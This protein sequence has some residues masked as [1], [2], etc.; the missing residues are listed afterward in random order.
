MSANIDLVLDSGGT[1]ILSGTIPT[2]TKNDTYTFRLRMQDLSAG[3]TPQDVD[4]S[5]STIKLAIG[6]INE[7]PTDGQF[8]LTLAGPVTSTAISFNATTTQFFN[9]IS[10]IAGNATVTTYGISSG[11]WL[12]TAATANT[13]L[14][15]GADSYTLFPSSSV[16]V[17]TRRNPATAVNAQQVVQLRRNPAVYANNFSP[18]STASAIVLTKVQDGGSGKNEVYQLSIQADA[19]G[20]SFYF[21]FG[22]NTTTGV[23]IGASA[24]CISEALQSLPNIGINNISTQTLPN[25]QGYSISFIGSLGSQNITTPLSIDAAGVYFAKWMSS[26]ITM[27]T[28]ELD[29]LFSET[30][31]LVITPTLEIELVDVGNPKTLYQGTVAVRSDL[32]TSGSVVP[33]PK[34]SYYTKAEA[35]NLFVED[36][37]T[38]V[39]A[40]NRKLRASNG[41]ERLRWDNGLGFFGATAVS[42][43]ANVN[44]ASGLVNLGLFASSSTYGVLPLSVKTLTVTTAIDFGTINSNDI[45]Y[46]N[47]TVTGANINDIV[48]VGLPNAVSDGLVIQGLVVTANTVCLSAINGLNASKHLGS[49]TFRIVVVG[50]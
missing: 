22:G 17:S 30:S 47:V 29:E 9:A 35:D 24:V 38:N 39:D 36:S 13:A 42:Q 4:I 31:S 25:G 14:S 26:S 7:L 10:A 45:H 50:Y 21:D 12:I 8:K 20:G 40:S 33:A 15:F 34:D 11:A 37:A 3:R 27:A 19:Q 43:Q 49:E 18:A 6:N 46:E 48:F 28:S 23:A 1:G 2:L 44:V 32:I 41:T 16:L 5:S